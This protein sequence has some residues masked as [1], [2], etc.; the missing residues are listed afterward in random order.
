MG[1]QLSM[2]ICHAIKIGEGGN[3]RSI[4]NSNWVLITFIVFIIL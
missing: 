2:T 4:V 1:Y 3:S